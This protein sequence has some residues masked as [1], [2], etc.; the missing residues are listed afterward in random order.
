MKPPKLVTTTLLTLAALLLLDKGVAR[1]DDIL[2]LG[3][4]AAVW[5]KESLPLGNGRLGC[6]V[7]GGVAEE[8]IQFNVDSLWTGDENPGGGYKT[9]GM[10]DYQNFGDL[11]VAV[12]GAG[13]ATDYRREL[14]LGTA[15]CRV[16]YQQDGTRFGRETFCSH[17]AQVLVSRMTANAKGKYSGRLRLVDGRTGKITAGPDGLAFS[18]TLPNGMDYEAQLRVKAEG[19]SLKPDGDALV[20]SGC[21]SLT[22]FLGAATSYVMD[23]SRKWKGENPRALVNKQ[24]DD[25]AEAPYAALLAAHVADHQSLYNRVAID[26]GQTD[27]ARLALPVDERLKAVRAGKADPDLAEL[28]FQYGRY[29]LIGCSRPGTLPANLQGLW[30]PTNQAAWHADY[31]SNINLQMNY[32]PA[33]TTNLGECHTPLFDLLTASLEPFRAATRKDFGEKIRGFTIRTSHNPF[34]GMGWKWNL[35]ASAWYARHFW[36]HYEFGQDKKFLATVA[37]PFMKEV[38]QYWED[39]LKELPDGRLV[40]PNGWSPEH[41]PTEDGVSYDQQIVWDLF[42]N[43]IDAARALGIDADHGRRLAAMRDKLVG[44]KIGKWGQLQEWL[45]DRDDPKDQHRHVSHLFAVY[46]GRQISA[47]TTPELAAAAATSLNARGDAATG[48]SRA[49]K[50]NLWARLHEG[51]RTHKVLTDMLS[52]NFYD[53]LFDSM[54]DLSSHFQIDGNFGYTAG[55]AEM[56]LQS[57]AGAIDLLPALPRA[58]PAGSVTGLRARGGFEVDLTWKNGK[59][60][61]ATIRNVSSPGGKCVIRHAGRQQPVE[62]ARGQARTLAAGEL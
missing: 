28:V 30:N 46:P 33:E 10:G 12:D 22:L 15:V 57:H 38:C 58:W 44:P 23:Y 3:K 14:N 40:V 59:P 27:A 43:T 4:P 61:R 1:A 45:D 42:S 9:P 60:T 53:N 32:W 17:P 35:P 39:H 2:F 24:V 7:F 36:E 52:R 37:Y 16:A 47:L 56:L 31:H 11:Y 26:L 62:I 19:G 18:G 48:W 21:D 6:T 54:N 41:G 20:F 13:T 49:W 29:L 25:A 50:I 51:D 34:G 8:R 55:L 5:E